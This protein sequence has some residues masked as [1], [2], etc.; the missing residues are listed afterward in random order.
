MEFTRSL[1]LATPNANSSEETNVWWNSAGTTA[2]SSTSGSS[3]VD[4]LDLITLIVQWILFVIGTVGNLMVLVVLVWRR[5]GS[6]VG[7]QLFVGSLAV[8]DIGLMFTTVWVE[9]YDTMT[10]NYHF[11]LI[12]C[13]IHKIGQWMTMNCSI[14]TLATLSMDRYLCPLRYH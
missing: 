8:S 13:K 6:Q 2:S 3:G 7:T 14:W 12:P 5:S 10:K 4:L 11:G 1:S 9:A